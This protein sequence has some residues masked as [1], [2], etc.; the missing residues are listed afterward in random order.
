[1]T[2]EQK[3]KRYAEIK[4]QIKLLEREL[5]L[6]KKDV[7]KAVF[8]EDKETL[9]KDYGVFKLS[10]RTTYRYSEALQEKERKLQVAKE[11]VDLEKK[12]EIAKGLAEI[13]KQVKILTFSDKK[14]K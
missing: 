14:E 9:E 12:A 5:T 13:D 10:Y 6:Y 3:L 2:T 11:V 8:D 1:M 4:V 7:E